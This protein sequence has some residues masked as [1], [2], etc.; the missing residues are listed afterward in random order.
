[1]MRSRQHL[2]G[3]RGIVIEQSQGHTH[4]LQLPCHVFQFPLQFCLSSIKTI[5][6]CNQFVIGS[7]VGSHKSSPSRNS[8]GST[9]DRLYCQHAIMLAD[10][11]EDGGIKPHRVS[12]RL[13]AYKAASTLNEL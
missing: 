13:T 5:S 11:A 7:V 12:A 2:S 3:R 10:V 6:Q 8:A 4:R 1:M 9:V